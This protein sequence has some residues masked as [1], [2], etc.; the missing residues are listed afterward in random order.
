MPKIDVVIG[1]PPYTNGV[2]LKHLRRAYEVAQRAVVFLH[3]MGWLHS[4]KP[5][6]NS[7]KERAEAIKRLIGQYFVSFR[8]L[9]GNKVFGIKFGQVCGITMIDK[10]RTSD[11]VIVEDITVGITKTFPNAMHINPLYLE[12]VVFEPLKDKLWDYC[13][14]HNIEHLINQSKGPYYVNLPL[15]SGH[16]D[17][18]GATDSFLKP[19]F[20]QLIY[21]SDKAVATSPK[22]TK[23]NR[24]LSFETE[25]EAQHCIEYLSNSKLAKFCLMIVKNQQNLH[26][27][28]LLYVPM[29]DF[30]NCW[31]DED[32]YAKIGLSDDQVSIIETIVK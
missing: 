27:G 28:K 32:L 1:N 26:R 12:P 4:Q 16:V 15:I 25:I 11:E 24:W 7:L 17:E 19:D 22:A 10:I 31:S 2:H 6:R 8:I 23:Q 3:P 20:Y 29:F 30:S 14:S 9:N 21:R 13:T 5:G 18:S